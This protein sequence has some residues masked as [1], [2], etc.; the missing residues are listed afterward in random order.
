MFLTSPPSVRAPYYTGS[1]DLAQSEPRVVW[2]P[3][4]EQQV[5]TS[6]WTIS[7]FYCYQERKTCQ[8]RP[9]TPSS[10]PLSQVRVSMTVFLKSLHFLTPSRSWSCRERE[11]GVG[12][13]EEEESG[14][15]WLVDSFVFWQCFPQFA[16][17]YFSC[18]DS[19][20]NFLFWR[21]G[22][23]F[24]SGFSVMVFWP[25]SKPK[26]WEPQLDQNNQGQRV[27]P[28]LLWWTISFTEMAEWKNN[29]KLRLVGWIHPHP[30]WFDTCKHM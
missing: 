8:T 6:Q 10:P 4:V 5:T 3:G 13:L 18:Q 7:N 11:W 28:A 14:E 21:W 19:V 22:W 15:I 20:N 30:S 1:F 9:N 23:E 27:G 2:S 24:G 17:R 29:C 16:A 25:F 26:E 12:R